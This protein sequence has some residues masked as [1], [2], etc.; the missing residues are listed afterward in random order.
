V[1]RGFCSK[2]GTSIYYKNLTNNKLDIA[3]G[4]LDD[5]QGIAP[6]AHINTR[7]QSYNIDDLA[8]LPAHQD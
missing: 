4:A 7:Q 3:Y 8:K 1:K 5:Q 6:V 2:C